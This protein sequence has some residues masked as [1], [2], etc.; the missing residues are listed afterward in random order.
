MDPTVNEYS[1][2]NSSDKPIHR[3]FSEVIS[4]YTPK[5]ASQ[6]Q[7]PFLHPPEAH[8]GGSQTNELLTL[9]KQLVLNLKQHRNHIHH[10]LN[11]EAAKNDTFFLSLINNINDVRTSTQNWMHER[12]SEVGDIFNNLYLEVQI[13]MY[14]LSKKE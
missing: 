4:K 2:M 5:K 14:R 9:Y 13:R 10:K 1:G 7:Q 3:V 8:T 11:Q 6:H 12:I